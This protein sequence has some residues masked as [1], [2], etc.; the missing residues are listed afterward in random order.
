MNK[1]LKSSFLVLS[2]MAIGIMSTL[3]LQNVDDVQ[4]GGPDVV[5]SGEV[6]LGQARLVVSSS[7]PKI[8]IQNLTLSP[9]CDV[10]DWVL[11]SC[12]PNYRGYIVFKGYGNG[13]YEDP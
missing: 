12:D 2:G 6:G 8:R 3:L 9:L 7:T 1:V 10:K 4:A 13:C 11:E 5:C